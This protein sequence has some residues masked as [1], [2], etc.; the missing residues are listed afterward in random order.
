MVDVGTHTLP[1][2]FITE[3]KNKLSQIVGF[4]LWVSI[5]FAVV[6]LIVLLIVSPF[7]DQYFSTTIFSKYWY[8]MLIGF[9]VTSMIA[10]LASLNIRLRRFKLNTTV[11]VAEA[12]STK[13]FNLLGGWMSL[14]GLGL[15]LSDTFSK[16]INLI[17]LI[18]KFPV[19][20]RINFPKLLT[21]HQLFAK[22]RKFPLYLMP[23]QW[24][25]TL[26]NQLVVWL[27]AFQF[28]KNNLGEL[29]MAIGLLGIPLNVLSNSFQPVI[30]E[31]LVNLR[32]GD[33]SHRFFDKMLLILLVLSVLCFCTIYLL[34]ASFFTWFLGDNWSG[35]NTIVNIFSWYYILLLLD[36]AFQNGFIIFDKQK[37]KLIFNL[38]DVLLLLIVA[39]GSISMS[40][41][42]ENLLILF[43]SVKMIISVARLVYLRKITQFK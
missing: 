19:S 12:A 20:T 22:Y 43:V 23:S 15:I 39:F 10:T 27:V 42:F 36:Q 32:D 7:L 29:T 26:S 5:F 41:S 31:R 21:T 33:K 3:K 18:I 4:S 37:N 8:V 28:T 11:S 16:I 1:M 38:I 24:V 25:G 40:I 2:A 6:F 35:V 17:I 9:L 13:S 30:T 14:Q 34:P